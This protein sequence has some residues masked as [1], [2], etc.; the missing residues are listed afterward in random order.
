[1]Q[2]VA[3]PLP[4]SI[5]ISFEAGKKLFESDRRLHGP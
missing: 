4:V 3:E 5:Q 1:M 2:I